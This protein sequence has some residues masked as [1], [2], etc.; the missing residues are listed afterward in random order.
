MD[1][2]TTERWQWLGSIVGDGSAKPQA[3]PWRLSPAHRTANPSWGRNSRRSWLSVVAC[4]FM[5]TVPPS[6]TVLSWIALEDFNGSLSATLETLRANGPSS[7]AAQYGPAFNLNTAFLY[8]AWILFQTVLYTYLP[9]K[10]KGQLTP[11]GMLLEYHTNGLLAWGVTVAL[12]VTGWATGTIDAAIVANHWEGLIVM[13]N[14]WGYAL[15]VLAYVKAYY[16][17]THVHDRK[18]SG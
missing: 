8:V 4:L 10:S 3:S 1:S 17:P 11:A 14:L 16:A 2:T 6:L 9:G 15:S 12:F 7:F 5:I 13:F 18:F